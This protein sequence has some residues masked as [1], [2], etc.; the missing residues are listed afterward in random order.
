MDE[1]VVARVEEEEFS[2]K[3]LVREIR[4][5]RELL[6]LVAI[7]NIIMLCLMFYVFFHLT[8]LVIAP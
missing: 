8:Q 4:G 1:R 3:L 2:G 5:I 6:A 7:L